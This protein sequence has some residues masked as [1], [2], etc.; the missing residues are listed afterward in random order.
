MPLK[1]AER[2]ATDMTARLRNNFDIQNPGHRLRPTTRGMIA[3]D[4]SAA[5]GESI[6]ARCFDILIS[7]GSPPQNCSPNPCRLVSQLAASL[8]APCVLFR[9]LSPLP[10]FD[11]A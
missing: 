1:S 11:D 8:P 7:S 9:R 4:L 6:S 3:I 10:G 2:S 5:D